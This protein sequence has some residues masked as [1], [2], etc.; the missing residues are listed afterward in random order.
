MILLK[1]STA[2]ADSDDLRATSRIAPARPPRMEF[3]MNCLCLEDR[4]DRPESRRQRSA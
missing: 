1:K 2:L 4:R 3:D